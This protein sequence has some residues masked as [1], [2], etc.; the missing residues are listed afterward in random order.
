MRRADRW[1]LLTVALSVFTLSGGG[2]AGATTWP[3]GLGASAAEGQG[4]PLPTTAPGSP[5]SSCPGLTP[6]VKVTWTAVSEPSNG[7]PVI[8]YT[9]L[10]STTS[11][12]SGYSPVATGVTTTSWTSGNLAAGSYWFEVAAVYGT[13]W[14]GTSSAA[15]AQ[16][17]ITLSLVCT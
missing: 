16:R 17:T 12:L 10:E 1:I 8:S 9:V 13:H 11:A 14:Q 6:T 4:G 5:T 3:V 15:T 2:T 7:T